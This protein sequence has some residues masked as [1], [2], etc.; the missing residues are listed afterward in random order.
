MANNYDNAAPVIDGQKVTVEWLAGDPRRIYRVLNTLVQ[1][2]LISDRLLAGRVDLTGSGSAVYEVSEA[3]FATY[4]SQ[5][6]TPLAEYPW[7]TTDPATLAQVKPL[8]DGLRTII[9]DEAIAH[10]RIDKVV[11][12]LVKISNTLVAKADGLALAAIASKVT[13]IVNV[14]S[15]WTAADANPFADLALAAATVDEL[16]RGYAPNVVALRPVAFAYL[17]SRAGV[18]N[19]MP[20]EDANSIAQTGNLARFAGMT[21]VKSTHMPA[22]VGAILADSTMLGSLAWERLGGGYQGD[23]NP[24]GGTSGV[25]SKKYREEDKDGVTVQARLVRAPMVTEPGAA[26]LFPSTSIGV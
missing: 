18:M 8:K 24:D 25:E 14:A 3:I 15:K 4:Q 7:T 9:S 11:R 12:D 23:P 5:T 10:N 16:D 1:A 22:G 17:I 21:Y 13:Q 26:V 2:R 6:V 19:M 20:R